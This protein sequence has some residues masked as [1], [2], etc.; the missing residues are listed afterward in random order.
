ALGAV[1][2]YDSAIGS[3]S[4]RIQQRDILGDISHAISFEHQALQGRLEDVGQDV[5][6]NAR[7]NTQRCDNR[8]ADVFQDKRAARWS[9]QLPIDLD[10]HATR[11]QGWKVR[12]VERLQ[13]SGAYF[14]GATA[15]Q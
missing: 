4:E 6:P 3:R 8:L 11:P 1:H 5:R 14:D 2:N 15:T 10:V 7:E 12:R 9:N 13:P